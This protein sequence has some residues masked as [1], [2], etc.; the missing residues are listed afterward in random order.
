MQL[1]AKVKRGLGEGGFWVKK[2]EEIFIY[3]E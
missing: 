3:G 2:I 1:E